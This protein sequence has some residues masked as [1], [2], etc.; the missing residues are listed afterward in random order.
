MKFGTHNVER[1]KALAD[2]GNMVVEWGGCWSGKGKE[3]KVQKMEER[4]FEGGMDEV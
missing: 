3:N 4:K 2:I 1:Q